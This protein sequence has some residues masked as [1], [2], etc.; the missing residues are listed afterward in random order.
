MLKSIMKNFEVVIANIS[1]LLMVL[2]LTVQIV[3]RY[4]FQMSIAWTEELSRFMFLN[5][6]YLAS[7]YVMMKKKHIN[8]GFLLDLLPAPI[9][10]ILVLIGDVIQILFCLIAGYSGILLVLDMIAY[11]VLSPSLMIPL[12][13]S[14]LIIPLAFFLMAIRIAQNLFQDLLAKKEDV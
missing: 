13:Y 4:F 7:S 9:K 10:Q 14:Y 8:V 2:C 1:L 11:P 5:F 12:Y 6:V 3:A